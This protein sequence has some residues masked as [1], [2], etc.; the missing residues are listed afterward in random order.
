MEKAGNRKRAGI[1]H[2]RIKKTSWYTLAVFLF[3]EQDTME[4]FSESCWRESSAT[5]KFCCLLCA[6]LGK[7]ENYSVQNAVRHYKLCHGLNA[8]GSKL[9]TLQKQC[10]KRYDKP[11]V[12]IEGNGT[13]YRIDE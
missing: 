8:T 4:I 1:Y 12:V 7:K 5:G 10:R 9:H 2:T 11:T 13:T 6:A 3:L